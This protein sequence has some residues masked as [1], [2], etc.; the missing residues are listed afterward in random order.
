M[1]EGGRRCCRF[2]PWWRGRDRREQKQRPSGGGAAECGRAGALE[3]SV[4][5]ALLASFPAFAS[6]PCF[7]SPPERCEELPWCCR[8]GGGDQGPPVPSGHNRDTQRARGLQAARWVGGAGAWQGWLGGAAAA[9]NCWLCGCSLLGFAAR[10]E[11]LPTAG[12]SSGPGV[13]PPLSRTATSTQPAAAG[14]LAWLAACLA[15]LADGRSIADLD[16]MKAAAEEL[17][18]YGPQ[19]G[20][21]GLGWG[22]ARAALHMPLLLSGAA[23]C[24]LLLW[25]LLLQRR[26]D[27]AACGVGGWLAG[28]LACWPGAPTGPPRS[29]PAGRCCTPCEQRHEP[30]AAALAHH[31]PPSC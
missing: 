11:L 17:H 20:R 5:S 4:G 8:R 15:W 31:L 9:V 30:P 14:L 2:R 25:G 6:L 29:R 18:R 28:L 22:S 21:G 13:C 24:G 3:L 10:R 12:K 1:A 19:A 23:A 16:G 26:Q 27:G 7:P